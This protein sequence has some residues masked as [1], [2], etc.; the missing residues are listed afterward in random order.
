[1]SFRWCRRF[2]PWEAKKGMCRDASCWMA[3]EPR[4]IPN[5]R[6]AARDRTSRCNY[7]IPITLLARA[8]RKHMR[9]VAALT[10][11][12]RR[13]HRV[14]SRLAVGLSQIAC[15]NGAIIHNHAQQGGA[16]ND[17]R[18]YSGLRVRPL[19]ARHR[20]RPR[21]RT[22]LRRPKMIFDYSLA[23]LVAAGLLCY[24]LYALLRPERF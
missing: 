6:S 9:V 10:E 16:F 15:R 24:L 3:S 11:K 13:R 4:S 23:A 8:S 7:E 22:A 20:L 19:C 1:M 14:A 18:Y 21:L 2:E 12:M 5:W 17:G